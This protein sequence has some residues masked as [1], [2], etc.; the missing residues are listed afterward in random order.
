M[1]SR[2]PMPSLVAAHQRAAIASCK[3]SGCSQV[4]QRSSA[5]SLMSTRAGDAEFISVRTG[6]S[7]GPNG[8]RLGS[9]IRCQRKHPSVVSPYARKRPR[10]TKSR[11]FEPL[12]EASLIQLQLSILAKWRNLAGMANWR[13]ECPP[14]SDKQ[15]GIVNRSGSPMPAPEALHI[16]GR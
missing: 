2:R 3:T 5:D 10:V 7:V 15:N 6:P 11:P 8:D 16:R 14:P 12:G 1:H 13:T 4:G 9:P